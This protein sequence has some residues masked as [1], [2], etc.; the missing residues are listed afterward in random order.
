ML[1]QYTGSFALCK[2]WEIFLRVKKEKKTKNMYKHSDLCVSILA[3]QP[4]SACYVNAK[5]VI[6]LKKFLDISR[7]VYGNKTRYFKATPVI[8]STL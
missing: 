3:H 5:P 4:I 7:C 8:F 2:G 6:F 1:N